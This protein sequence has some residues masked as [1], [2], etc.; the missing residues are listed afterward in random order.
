MTSICGH[1]SERQWSDGMGKMGIYTAAS[2]LSGA[3]AAAAQSGQP[4]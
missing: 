3:G 1:G 4:N 2:S